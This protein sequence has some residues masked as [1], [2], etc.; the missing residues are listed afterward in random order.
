MRE[1]RGESPSYVSVF[2]PLPSR[3]PKEGRSIEDRATGKTR[4]EVEDRVTTCGGTGG[5]RGLKGG[6]GA[7]AMH[8]GHSSDPVTSAATLAATCSPV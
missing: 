7:G 6:G 5:R 1:E 8:R 3:S 4:A 2:L